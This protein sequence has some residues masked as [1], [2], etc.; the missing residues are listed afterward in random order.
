[1]WKASNRA[2]ICTG[3]EKQIKTT[4]DAEIHE[5]YAAQQHILKALDLTNSKKCDQS[6][7][8]L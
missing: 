8:L 2:R 1:M 4:E 3:D 6:D 7:V 5:L